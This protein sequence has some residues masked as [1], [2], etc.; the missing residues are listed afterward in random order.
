M[1][2]QIEVSF[3]CF[4]HYIYLLYMIFA[5]YIFHTFFFFYNKIFNCSYC[6][7]KDLF[8][9]LLLKEQKRL[10]INRLSVLVN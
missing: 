10:K 6:D 8:F 4:L 9:E 3:D 7:G 1:L 2:L 5:L